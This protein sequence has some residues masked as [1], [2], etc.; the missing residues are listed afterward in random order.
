MRKLWYR[1]DCWLCKDIIQE[2]LT[3]YNVQSHR[4]GY[5]AGFKDGYKAGFKDGY[6]AAHNLFCRRCSKPT[7][8]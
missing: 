4:E 1:F 8:I 7:G 2:E 3:K 6:Q 5:K